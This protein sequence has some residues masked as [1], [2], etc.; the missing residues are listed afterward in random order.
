[1]TALELTHEQIE[2]IFMANY[3][4]FGFFEPEIIDIH[5]HDGATYFMV[6]D[7][8]YDSGDDEATRSFVVVEAEGPGSYPP[9]IDF[10]EL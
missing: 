5:D 6:E 3:R 9:G 10:E 7:Y 8:Y 1:M 2:S 4:D